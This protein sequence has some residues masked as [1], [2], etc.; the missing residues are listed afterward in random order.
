MAITMRTVLSTY[1][2][3]PVPIKEVPSTSRPIEGVGTSPAAFVGLVP[4]N[5]LRL[6]TTVLVASCIA[7]AVL[8]A[9]SATRST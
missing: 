1:I 8:R 2:P 4:L 5:P 9:R 3:P 6:G 7:L